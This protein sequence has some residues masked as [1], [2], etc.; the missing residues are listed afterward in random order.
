M[1]VRAHQ[2]ALRNPA[3]R[4]GRVQRHAAVVRHP[5]RAGNGVPPSCSSRPPA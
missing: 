2:A 3:R 1:Q 5:L 4:V